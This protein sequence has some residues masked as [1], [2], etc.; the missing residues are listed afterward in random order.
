MSTASSSSAISLLADE[1]EDLF[2]TIQEIRALPEPSGGELG[3][4][5]SPVE[6][7]S[8]SSAEPDR[9]AFDSTSASSATAAMPFN[10]FVRRL[11]R[12]D[13]F[14]EAGIKAK[15]AEDRIRAGERVATHE[16]ITT[17]YNALMRQYISFLS[18][19]RR[20]LMDALEGDSSAPENEREMTSYAI[21]QRDALNFHFMVHLKRI[22]T[23]LSGGKPISYSVTI[24]YR[25]QFNDPRIKNLDVTKKGEYN[26]VH[27]DDLYNLSAFP[28][29][30]E[31]RRLA[32]D[33]TIIPEAVSN[34]VRTNTWLEELDLSSATRI[35]QDG[36]DA[37]YKTF[38]DQRVGRSKTSYGNSTLVR[39]RM[40][41]FA[42]HSSHGTS[43]SEMIRNNSSI[44]VLA[45][46]DTGVGHNAMSQIIPALAFNTTIVDLDLSGNRIGFSVSGQS[47]PE[48]CE[49]LRDHNRTLRSLNVSSC[50]LK[51][52][53]I[54]TLADSLSANGT[55]RELDIS[56]NRLAPSSQDIA[57]VIERA[58]S[59]LSLN[60]SACGFEGSELT[61]IMQAL[62]DNP[63][64]LVSLNVSNNNSL[65]SEPV[66]IEFA[67]YI[68]RSQ[69]LRNLSMSNM[70][71]HHELLYAHIGPALA[72]NE[73]IVTLNIKRTEF[74]ERGFS[75]L[76]EA[77][78]NN[79]WLRSLDVS[80]ST[81]TP[82]G[83]A[84]FST[85]FEV[86]DSRL[87]RFE[88]RNCLIDDQGAEA[89]FLSAVKGGSLSHIDLS[90]NGIGRK[91]IL[92]HDDM[93][94]E[95]RVLVNSS[96]GS[97]AIANLIANNTA[98]RHLDLSSNRLDAVN[99][100][101]IANSLRFSRTLRHLNLGGNV[102]HPNAEDYIIDALERNASIIEFPYNFGDGP[103]ARVKRARVDDILERNKHNRM[104]VGMSLS[105]LALM[106]AQSVPTREFLATVPKGI[107]NLAR[108]RFELDMFQ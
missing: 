47:F 52:T 60:I 21:A 24:A 87:T 72:K 88:A 100:A 2:D 4:L 25:V 85:L 56:S 50:G 39:L 91:F 11:R 93:G 40:P 64:R 33:G 95:H 5:S 20:T 15:L 7:D 17:Y 9:L 48:F 81:F 41:E 103:L 18:A 38:Y 76:G 63:D 79:Y 27:G 62:A 71:F 3:Y 23:A 102:N 106:A 82:A 51:L 37:I 46:H 22:Q 26:G 55:L 28:E 19:Y 94:R 61:P 99:T 12:S 29:N 14:Y 108:R 66:A 84:K 92:D 90:H 96:S 45:V 70:A 89:F 43:L 1:D 30:T 10:L 104:R 59:L 6:I 32:L 65:D 101:I 31:V 75:Q 78:E 80:A 36:V 58:T 83:F 73:R 13:D 44:M 98:L 34:M 42:G 35:G 16:E 57:N 74:G 67:K 77:L 97:T 54:E 105:S 8:S 68:E 86:A 69:R 107:A 49:M 53:D